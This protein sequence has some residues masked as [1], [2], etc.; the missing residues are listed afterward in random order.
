MGNKITCEQVEEVAELVNRWVAENLEPDSDVAVIT[1][2]KCKDGT[3]KVVASSTAVKSS[4]VVWEDLP[5]FIDKEPYT[6]L[7]AYGMEHPV[8]L[9]TKPEPVNL[10]HMWHVFETLNYLSQKVREELEYA[11][12]RNETVKPVSW[13][14]LP[15][16]GTS[17]NVPGDTPR[18]VLKNVFLA[19]VYAF[20]RQVVIDNRGMSPLVTRGVNRP[21]ITGLSKLPKVVRAGDGRSV[22]DVLGGVAL[23]LSVRGV[24]LD[25]VFQESILVDIASAKASEIAV[26]KA[27]KY[28]E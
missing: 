22:R 26:D 15:G 14:C 21:E 6:Q 13:V 25:D 27:A 4:S 5:S 19:H 24:E 28:W 3:A 10:S 9:E 16:L 1:A 12:S 7:K 20:L 11:V 8:I 18:E 23:E 2:E 17:A